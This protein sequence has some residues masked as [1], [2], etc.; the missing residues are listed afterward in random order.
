[1]QD[2]FDELRQLKD[3]RARS[4]ETIRQ[5]DQMIASREDQIAHLTALERR[6][7]M[8]RINGGA[9]WA[10]VAG[11]AG[12]LREAAKESPGVAIAASATVAVTAAAVLA[13]PIIGGDDRPAG[14]APRQ[15]ISQPSAP[16]PTVPPTPARRP[17]PAPDARPKQPRQVEALPVRP[18]ADAEQAA[19]VIPIDE[20][21]T[22]EPAVPVEQ[23]ESPPPVEALP[24]P[25]CVADVHLLDIAEVR[26]LCS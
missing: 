9:V 18:P 19:A 14:A 12:L 26:L 16:Q 6:A 2:I 21:S 17:E 8:R 25:V 24:A 3:A 22:P 4:R 20:A 11:A 15:S 23:P 5:I 7:W 1:M 10:T 13:L